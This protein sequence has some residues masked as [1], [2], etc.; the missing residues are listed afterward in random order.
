MMMPC[1]PGLVF[2]L[3]GFLT[4]PHR[5]VR[6]LSPAGQV[7]YEEAWARTRGLLLAGGVVL[8]IGTLGSALVVWKIARSGPL[9]E[10]EPSETGEELLL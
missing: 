9:H 10:Q 7:R 1:L 5:Q 8:M 3:V 4:D 6:D 2:L